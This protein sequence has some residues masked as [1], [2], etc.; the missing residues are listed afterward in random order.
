MLGLPYILTALLMTF[1][2]DD[3]LAAKPLAVSH[4][5]SSSSAARFSSSAYSSHSR[6]RAAGGTF[7]LA[8]LL[9]NGFFKTYLLACV[10]MLG[11]SSSGPRSS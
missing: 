4:A 9:R 2:H 10:P 7:A 1:L 3:D 8:F 5:H 11:G 6:L